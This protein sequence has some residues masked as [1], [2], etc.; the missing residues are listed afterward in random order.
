[1]RPMISILDA[2]WHLFVKLAELGS[3]SKT[4]ANLGV[5]QSMVSRHLTKLEQECGIRLFRRT[6]RGVVLTEFGEQLFPR[7][8]AM[9][10]AAEVL[11]DDILTSGG[12]PTGEVRVGLLPST[13][14]QLAGLLFS[15]LHAR[16]PKIRLHLTE[17]SSAHLEEMVL[18]GRVDMAMLA[19]ESDQV[20]GDEPLLGK[21]SLYV[22]GRCDDP[23]LQDGVIAFDMLHG[24]PLVL[25]STPHPLRARLDQIARARGLALNMAIDADTMRLQ[26]AIAAEGG[27][28]AI[29]GGGLVGAVHGETRLKAA[30]VVEPEL[31]RTIVLSTTLRRPHTQATREV[32]KLLQQVVPPALRQASSKQ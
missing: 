12:M 7:V 6:G 19:R 13:V 21:H 31:Q 30:R 24:L 5:P 18:S 11:A 29:T 9:M 25:P 10:A 14:P 16:F 22:V 27:G 8:T 3:L 1:V 28:Y 4:A 23:L 26:H 20:H 15:T 2:K 17:G 32:Y